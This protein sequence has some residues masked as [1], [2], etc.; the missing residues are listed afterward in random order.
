[1]T[2]TLWN[3]SDKSAAITLSSGGHIATATAGGNNG[4][5]ATVS[6][7]T[8]NWYIEFSAITEAGSGRL[9]FAASGDTLGG[10]GQLG[11]DFGGNVHDGAGNSYGDFTGTSPVGHNISWAISFTNGKFWLRYDG[12]NWNNSGTANPA[13]N[14]GGHPLNTASALFPYRWFQ[15]NPGTETINS[16]DVADG[17]P[18]FTYAVPAGFT[19][20]GLSASP[21]GTWISTEATDIFSARGYPG[22]PGV[23][24][25]LAAT[26]SPDVFAAVGSP[27]VIGTWASTENPDIFGAS[28][29]IPVKGPWA[30][31]EAKDIFAAAGIGRGEDLVWLSTEG[32]DIFAATGY[33]RVSG[34]LSSTE[35][36]DRFIALGAGVTQVRR[37]RRIFVT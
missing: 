26:G 7:V 24:G 29:H 8:L 30:S 32:V 21:T 18:A 22:Y 11:L 13:T 16:G 9:G 12:G 4:V 35:A 33:T 1:M 28:G 19:A 23:V 31:T 5:R 6:H 25:D 27:A 15:N 34:V 20:W 17:D 36:T 10:N 14:T 3:P 37:R 2:Q